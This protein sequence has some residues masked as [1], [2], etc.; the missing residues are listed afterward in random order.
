MENK[1]MPWFLK[2]RKQ[3]RMRSMRRF[4]IAL[5]I[6]TCLILPVLYGFWGYLNASAALIT[7]KGAVLEKQVSPGPASSIVPTPT[8]TST[9]KPTPAPTPTPKPADSYLGYKAHIFSSQGNSLTYYLY[10]PANY[11]PLQ[12]YP[13]MLVLHGGG[14]RSNPNSSKAANEKLLVSNPYVSVWS[15]AYNA[16][17]N[18]QIQ[19][20]WPSFIV[21]PQMTLS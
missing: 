6:V 19:K 1:F 11:N 5:T 16:P 12:K 21:V 18:P 3:K 2:W 4:L 20:N 14:E 15:S 10:T 7:F 17:G 13:L 8:L 9:P